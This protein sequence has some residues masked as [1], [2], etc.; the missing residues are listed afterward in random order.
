MNPSI[1]EMAGALPIAVAM[2]LATSCSEAGADRADTATVIDVRPFEEVQ[3]G[4][5]T[6][7]GDP[8]DP[9]RGVFRVK[10]TEPM[11]CAI[12]WGEDD[13]FGRFNNSQS[14]DGTGII[15][16]D[17][18]LPDVEPGKRYRFVVQGTTAD[19][20]LYRSEV[21]SFT[22]E[23][24][25]GGTAGAS[26]PPGDNVAVGATI[27]DA[28][29]SFSASFAPELAV[30]GDLSTE[31]STKGDGDGAFLVL[32][33]GE[34]VEIGSVEFVTRSMSDGSAVTETFTVAVDGEEPLGPFPAAS[35]ARPRPVDLG[36]SGRVFRFEVASSTGGNVGAAEIALYRPRR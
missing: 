2:L 21:S 17:V 25:T 19:G 27:L 36:R 32:D 9:S 6:F 34:T 13:R 15:D 18:A 12:V 26:A 5:L 22:I 7:E 16:H 24:Q 3:D 23:P 4:P 30:D 28:S 11:I 14:M 1:R 20:T 10:T 35:P 8:A 31:W 29:S 33:L